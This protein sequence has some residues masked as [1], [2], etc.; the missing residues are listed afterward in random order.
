VEL[1]F[2]RWKDQL[3]IDYLK[4]INGNRIDCLIFSRLCTVVIVELISGY[5]K[6]MATKLFDLEVSEV[7]LINYLLRDSI[8]YYAVAENRL[9]DFLE[10]M[11]RYAPRMLLK[12]RR[13]RKTMR[14]RV[15]ESESYYEMQRFDYQSVA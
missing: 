10:E 14:E 15:L 7:K 11:M 6:K 4:G 8:F 1:I 9:E 3:E 2:K 13:R 12:D 5:F